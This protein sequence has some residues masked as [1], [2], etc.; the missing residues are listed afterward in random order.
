MPLHAENA[1]QFI[2]IILMHILMV[3]SYKEHPH[4]YKNSWSFTDFLSYEDLQ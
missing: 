3:Q 2:L 1:K 4:L